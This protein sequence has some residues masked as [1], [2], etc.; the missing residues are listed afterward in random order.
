MA[1]EYSYLF[2]KINECLESRPH[3]NWVLTQSDKPNIAYILQLGRHGSNMRVFIS[4]PKEDNK[5]GSA[6]I[7]LEL[8]PE[9]FRIVQQ[10]IKAHPKFN[11]QEPFKK[12]KGMIFVNAHDTESPEADTWKKGGVVFWFAYLN[13]PASE[14]LYQRMSLWYVDCLESIFEFLKTVAQWNQIQ[15]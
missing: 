2:D 10:Y 3:L 8:G 13:N 14:E 5:P 11:E 6:D 7:S 1:P 15:K 4:H 12:D 9:D